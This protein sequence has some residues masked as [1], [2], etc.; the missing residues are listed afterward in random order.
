M[1]HIGTQLKRLLES[2]HETFVILVT[3]VINHL[4]KKITCQDI[5][6][7][8]M[9]KIGIFVTNVINY[10]IIEKITYKDIFNPNMKNMRIKL[11]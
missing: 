8:N 5:F 6:N 11:Q 2:V 10:L 1:K 7:L 3:N 9:K 4:I